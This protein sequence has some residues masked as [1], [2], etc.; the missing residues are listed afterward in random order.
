[1]KHQDTLRV[2]TFDR[3]KAHRWPRHGFADGLGIGSANMVCVVIA[4]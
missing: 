1:M 2:L 4:V 3:Y